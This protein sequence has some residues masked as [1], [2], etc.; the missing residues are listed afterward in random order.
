MYKCGWVWYV[1]TLRCR[2]QSVSTQS[3]RTNIHLYTN[4]IKENKKEHVHTVS[5]NQK[6]T[7]QKSGVSKSPYLCDNEVYI[8]NDGRQSMKNKLWGTIKSYQQVSLAKFRLT[9]I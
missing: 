9:L 7:E 1:L 8:V 4:K 2:S 3:K 5:T 6:H